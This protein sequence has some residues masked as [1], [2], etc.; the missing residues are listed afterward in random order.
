MAI[1]KV[2]DHPEEGGTLIIRSVACS[3][4]HWR[5]WEKLGSVSSFLAWKNSFIFSCT[6]KTQTQTQ[7]NATR[8]FLLL[9]PCTVMALLWGATFPGLWQDTSVVQFREGHLRTLRDGTVQLTLS[10]DLTSSFSAPNFQQAASPELRASRL[11]STR[12]LWW[13]F[14]PYGSAECRC[15]STGSFKLSFLLGSWDPGCQGRNIQP[16]CS[17]DFL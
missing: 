9:W 15:V 5:T 6:W 1:K 13:N 11:V 16:I 3:A 10:L 2:G 17:L 4:Q 7:E 8:H 14:Q 12:S